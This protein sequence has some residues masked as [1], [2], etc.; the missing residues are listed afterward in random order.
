MVVKS[1]PT[2]DN[3][4]IEIDI[5]V[6]FKCKNDDESIKS[7]VYKISIN[8]LNEQLEAAITERM[9]VLVRGK[10]HLEVY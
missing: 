3:V 6:V 2:Y 5:G 9:R 4:F 1:C 8:Q 10:T 7:F